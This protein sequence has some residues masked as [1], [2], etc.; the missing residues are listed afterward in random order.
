MNRIASRGGHPARGFTLIEVLV[1]LVI[2][3]IGLLGLGL[4]QASS[5]KASFGANHRTIATN[6]AY[7]MLDLMRSNRNSAYLYTDI[8]QANFPGIDPTTCPAQQYTNMGNAV[9]DDITNWQCQVA[10]DLPTG[11]AD[12]T[13]VAGV[14]TVTILW[15]DARF[16]VGQ[17]TNQF[18]LTTQL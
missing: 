1:S 8:V 18:T 11:R 15:T 14:A 12:V 13:L 5:L 16:R 17:D 4:L 2:L 10:H 7:Q 3:S 9:A 6:L